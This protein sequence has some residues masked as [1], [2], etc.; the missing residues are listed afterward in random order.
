LTAEQAPQLVKQQHLKS[1]PAARGGKVVLVIVTLIIAQAMGISN[2]PALREINDI[3][4]FIVDV[5]QEARQKYSYADFVMRTK[6]WIFKRVLCRT[7]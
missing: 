3:Y 4:I 1:L 7:I 2:C 5:N 6:A